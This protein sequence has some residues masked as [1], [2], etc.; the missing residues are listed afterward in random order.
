MR[1]FH[2][3]FFF[4]VLAVLSISSCSHNTD[5]LDRNESLRVLDAKIK[6]DSNN[7]DL[8]YQRSLILIDMGKDSSRSSYFKDAIAD[9]Q[10]ATHIDNT[11]PDY[12]TA[13]ADAHF[14]LGNVGNSYTALQKALAIDP[15]NFEAHLK[16][17]EIAF[18]SKDYDRAIESLNHVTEKDRNNQTALFMKGFIYKENGDTTSAVYYFRRLIDL[19]PDYE[20]AYEELGFLF[21][22]HRNKLGI[23]YLTTA[24][25]LQPDNINILYALAQT[26]QEAE[27][28]ETASNYYVRILEIDSTYKYAWFNRGRMEMELYEDYINATEF[29]SKAIQCDPQFA[30]AYHNLGLTYEL[31]GDNTKAEGYYAQ[32]RQ[33]G[34]GS[35]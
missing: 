6:R 19:Y 25:S 18:Y 20:P 29:F 26:Y 12:F 14:S 22:Q 9:L 16:M 30:E 4:T 17:G 34:Y 3:T 2:Y 1:P 32:A 11:K 27:D 28:A 8:Y 21:S 15:D 10:R 13:L 31:M 5:N 23:E 7:A 24:L 33:L 35:E